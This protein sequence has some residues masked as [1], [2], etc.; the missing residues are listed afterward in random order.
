MNWSAKLEQLIGILDQNPQRDAANQSRHRV[1]SHENYHRS[2]IITKSLT[3]FTETSGAES[4]NTLGSNKHENCITNRNDD[5][6]VGG[7]NQFVCSRASQLV[8]MRCAVALRTKH[9]V[10]RSLRGSLNCN[11]SATEEGSCGEDASVILPKFV[12][13]SRSLA[14]GCKPAESSVSS[15]F[16]RYKEIRRKSMRS[17]SPIY[18]S[19][20]T[21][22]F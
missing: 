14:R 20:L 9:S 6:C 15:T 7:P 3:P 2:F 18:H 22:D 8:A 19:S 13:H 4:V 16:S 21:D 12:L 1:E 5:A 10:P 11:R 17:Q